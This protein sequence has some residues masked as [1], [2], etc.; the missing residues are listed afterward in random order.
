MMFITLQAH[1][2]LIC[3]VLFSPLSSIGEFYTIIHINMH[4]L[5][6]CSVLHAL[7]VSIWAYIVLGFLV[8]RPI[9]L[10]LS[11]YDVKLVIDILFTSV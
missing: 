3:I 7:F 11:Y 6:K 5:P 2:S 10:A 1:F 8:P 4:C 9:G